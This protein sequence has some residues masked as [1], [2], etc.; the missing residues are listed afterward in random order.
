MKVKELNLKN[1]AK[2]DIT[3]NIIIKKAEMQNRI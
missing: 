1:F 2:Y 3:T